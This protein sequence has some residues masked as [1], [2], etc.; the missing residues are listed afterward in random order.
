[1]LIAHAAHG[2]RRKNAYAFSRPNLVVMCESMIDRNARNK[3]AELIR[4]LVAGNITNDEFEASLPTSTDDAV[5]EVFH[6]GAW[7]LYSDMKAYK[8]RGEYALSPEDK[9]VV[10]RWV[11]F[12][13]RTMNTNGRQLAFEKR[14]SNQFLWV[15]LAKVRST[16][17]KIMVMLPIGHL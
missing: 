5:W 11:L 4:S 1:M 6:N 17:G 8:L 14:Y 12:L 9:T 10:A 13:N 2:L 16:N 3:L 15:F 7:C